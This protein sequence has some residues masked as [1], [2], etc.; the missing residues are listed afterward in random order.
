MNLVKGRYIQKENIN[1]NNKSHCLPLNRQISKKSTDKKEQ[2]EDPQQ[3]KEY[4]ACIYEYLREIEEK[5]T[6]DYILLLSIQNEYYQTMRSIIIERLITLHNCYQKRLHQESLHLAINIFDRYASLVKISVQKIDLIG[7]TSLFIAY[8]FEEPRPPFI[9]NFLFLSG[10]KYT[11]SELLKTEYNILSTLN[12]DILTVTP[13][14]FLNYYLN[15]CSMD[16][17][18][19]WLSQYLLDTC[20]LD[21]EFCGFKSS[22]KAVSVLYLARYIGKVNE[23]WDNELRF[24]SGL[25]RN[26]FKK[27]LRIALKFI[28]KNKEKLKERPIYAKYNTSTY[29]YSAMGLNRMK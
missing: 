7:I 12:F 21:I 5:N 14:T 25:K 2:R 1:L 13:V 16:I 9:S 28:E 23:V 24:H 15:H 4:S 26:D 20:S 18:I 19:T 17:K 10:N 6:P 11:K 27:C 8:K 22:I 3:L 29:G